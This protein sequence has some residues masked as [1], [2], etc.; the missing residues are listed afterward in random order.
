MPLVHR[1]QQRRSPD[2]V[3][4]ALILIALITVVALSR[5][6]DSH[7]P[8][9]DPSFEEEKLYL[10]GNTAKRLSLGF[11]GIA[12][13]Y[14][15]MRSLQYLGRKVVNYEDNS[16]EQLSLNDLSV[17]ELHLLPSLLRVS[18]SLDPEFMGPY[19]LG[20]M[21]LPTFNTDEAVTLLNY[22]IEH[23]PDAWRLYQHLG[24]IY[25]QQHDYQKSSEI[26]G[27]GARIAGAPKWMAEMSARVAA[28]GGS[29]NAARD[30]YQHLYDE[31][32]DDQ[33][34]ELIKRRLMQVESFDERDAIRA[35]LKDFQTRTGHC[36]SSWKDIAQALRASRLRIDVQTGAPV[37]PSDTPYVLAKNGCDVDLDYPRSKVPYR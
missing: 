30:T 6:L 22:G 33:V 36:A 28:E 37:D 15:W 19:E 29:R 24:Y 21:I 7:R 20:A 26:Y 10:S 23:N 2:V 3:L 18:T 31:S 32:K 14:Y 27:K 16:T 11:N 17:L 8:P 5:W 12:A 1:I 34:K 35:A 9:M 4:V 25:W 13:D